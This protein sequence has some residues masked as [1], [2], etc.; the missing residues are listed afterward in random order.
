MDDTAAIDRLLRKEG[1]RTDASLLE[2][3]A[4]LL[5]A[6]R[7]YRWRI[8]EFQKLADDGYD[9]GDRRVL[10]ASRTI[11]HFILTGRLP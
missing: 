9:A 4:A 5:Q 7:T 2:D 6:R 10:R 8:A 11:L 1:V 3:I